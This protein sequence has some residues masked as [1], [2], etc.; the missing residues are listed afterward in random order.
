MRQN[1]YLHI[2]FRH[3]VKAFESAGVIIDEQLAKDA[4]KM[5]FNV[6]KVSNLTAE[7][8]SLFIHQI[9]HY[10]QTRFDYYIPDPKTEPQFF[11]IEKAA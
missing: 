10:C 8:K 7:E 11:Q 6:A 4:M 1:N 9:Q 5:R 2:V 3:V